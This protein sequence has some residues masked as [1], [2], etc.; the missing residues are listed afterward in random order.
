MLIFSFVKERRYCNAGS[1]RRQEKILLN[2]KNSRIGITQPMGQGLSKLVQEGID[3]LL[4]GFEANP[5][6][7]PK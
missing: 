2:S 1:A 4:G 6:V 7:Q 5:E 3:Q